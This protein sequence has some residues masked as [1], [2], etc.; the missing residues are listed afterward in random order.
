MSSLVPTN[1]GSEKKE[2]RHVSD[3]RSRTWQP[4]RKPI[5]EELHECDIGLRKGFGALDPTPHLLLK[6][7]RKRG[8]RIPFM[9][10]RIQP[11]VVTLW[12]V[13][14]H[15]IL[16]VWQPVVPP[17]GSLYRFGLHSHAHFTVRSCLEYAAEQGIPHAFP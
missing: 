11:R 2:H 4:G 16:S 1:G 7:R 5:R 17:A 14:F 15:G 10:E 6:T 9:Q 8:L 12:I 3:G 13:G